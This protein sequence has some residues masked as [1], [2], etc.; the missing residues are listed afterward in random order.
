[1]RM[2]RGKCWSPQNAGC[3]REARC[4][5]RI[6]EARFPNR[7]RPR[8]FHHPKSHVCLACTT[9]TSLPTFA[10][11]SGCLATYNK[12]TV[13]FRRVQQWK[14][15]CLRWWIPLFLLPFPKT[16]PYFLILFL[17]SFALHSQPCMYCALI[18][19]GLFTTS[20]NWYSPSHS[21]VALDAVNTSSSTTLTNTSTP[22]SSY[23]WLDL[24]LS[25]G[26]GFFSP[27]AR[28]SSNSSS[29]TDNKAESDL[30]DSAFYRLS[31]PWSESQVQIPKRFYVGLGKHHG[32]GVWVD[33]GSGSSRASSLPRADTVAG[34]ASSTDS[35]SST[36]VPVQHVEL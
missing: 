23:G 20:S 32:L 13:S 33:L 12:A 16:S 15:Y 18:L 7:G 29:A 30:S 27:L 31:I 35:G 25:G 3:R 17:F 9:R 19:T 21:I 6:P 24:G 10:Y 26:N 34:T 22:R 1:M 11:L 14:M 36:A 28:P 2:K 5:R 8:K 4:T